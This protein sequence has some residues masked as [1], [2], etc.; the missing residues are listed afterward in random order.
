MNSKSGCYVNVDGDV[1]GYV[2]H[3]VKGDLSGLQDKLD[4]YLEGYKGHGISDLIYCI[5]CQNSIVPT[6]TVD[7]LYDN[8]EKTEEDGKSVN[9][10]GETHVRACYMAYNEMKD[11]IGYVIDKSKKDFNV[12][13]SYRM[14]DCHW[15][16]AETAPGRSKQLYYHA[17][18][19]D[20]F[21][22]DHVAGRWFGECL[23]YTDEHIRS[24]M[25][26]YIKET[27]YR[28][29]PYGIE[30]DFLREPF[31]FDY[32]KT[33]NA[34]EI[35]TD[36]MKK[37]KAVVTDYERE[38]GKKVKILVRLVRDIENNKIF[39]F[40][41]KEWVRLGLVDVLSPCSRWSDTDSDMPISEWKALCAGTDVEIAAG[42]EFYL[43]NNIKVSEECCKG[44]ASQYFDDGADK[45]YLYNYYREA[46]K[47]P[48]M[49][50]WNKAH[51]DFTLF[52][53][54]DDNTDD[55]K[56][57]NTEL[58][59]KIDQNKI[60]IWESSENITA[61]KSGKRRHV[62][63]FTEPC[64]VPKGGNSF[65]PLPLTVEGSAVLEKLTGDITDGKV[66]L[67][68]GVKAGVTPPRVKVDGSDATLLGK[69]RDAYFANPEYDGNEPTG[70]TCLDYYAYQPIVKEG[71][72]R[73][74]EFFADSTSVEYLE[75]MVEA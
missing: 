38:Y 33:P 6:E 57:W 32:E 31:C 27:V 51:P 67:F 43:W 52:K 50:E 54:T 42:L 58:L 61:A 24:V 45:I 28:Y 53:D 40:D 10:K 59:A 1:L 75:F 44:L 39:G 15:S 74:V 23:D 68:L 25:L 71:N 16:H 12:W 60:K 63:T 41:V 70:F 2:Y 4:L 65:M 19:N 22:G 47:L 48:D 56:L 11:P 13:L 14:N 5:F 49:T 66:T 73:S 46:V 29:H 35:I 17:K 69:T 9:Y 18:K 21:I 36:L 55:A 7:W 3:G 72:V 20:G 64:L 34:C 26:D 62:L 30:L 8:Y 37:I